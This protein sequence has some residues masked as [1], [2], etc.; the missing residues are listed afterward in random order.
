MSQLTESYIF[1]AK[2]EPL[3]RTHI[4]VAKILSLINQLPQ[5]YENIIWGHFWIPASQ[6]G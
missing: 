4:Q 2:I 3:Q 5:Q 6:T 1:L